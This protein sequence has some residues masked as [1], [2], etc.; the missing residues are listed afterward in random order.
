MLSANSDENPHSQSMFDIANE[1]A[2]SH[3]D[4]LLS[5]EARDTHAINVLISY[6]H[7]HECLELIFSLSFVG[8]AL[9]MKFVDQEPRHRAIPYQQ[10][11]STGEYLVNQI[12]NESFEGETISSE[13]QLEN[14]A[15]KS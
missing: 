15:Q 3:R 7:S 2:T 8:A 1:D 5:T 4:R 11:D 6:L 12:I 13:W 10:L 14:Y 9:V